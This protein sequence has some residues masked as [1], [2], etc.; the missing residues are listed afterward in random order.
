MDLVSYIIGVKRRFWN[1]IMD[2]FKKHECSVSD[3]DRDSGL[4]A[5]SNIVPLRHWHNREYD[6]LDD[7]EVLEMLRTYFTS[8]IAVLF[9]KDVA[10]YEQHREAISSLSDK[11]AGELGLKAPCYF[12]RS[13]ATEIS[14]KVD[15]IRYRLGAWELRISNVVVGAWLFK[16]MVDKELLQTLMPDTDFDKILPRLTRHGL[17]E[18]TQNASVRPSRMLLYR[19]IEQVAW[20]IDTMAPLVQKFCRPIL[21]EKLNHWPRVGEKVP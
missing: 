4:S 5:V 10:G 2:D 7:E 3:I 6:P 18:I 19:T 13:P 9:G 14:S 17:I 8:G 15:E 12:I 16:R 11:D 1:R 20:L 21:A